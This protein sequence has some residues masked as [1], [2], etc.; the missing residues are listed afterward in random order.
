[1]TMAS[2]KELNLNN[3]VAAEAWIISFEAKLLAKQKKSFDD[4]DR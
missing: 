1:M 2:P 3:P 4:A